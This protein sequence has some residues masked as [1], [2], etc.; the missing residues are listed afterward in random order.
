MYIIYFIIVNYTTSCK[1][2]THLFRISHKNVADQG[3]TKGILHKYI[4]QREIPSAF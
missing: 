3:K 1:P 2:Y 4:K